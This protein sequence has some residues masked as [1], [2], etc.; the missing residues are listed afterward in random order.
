M[1]RELKFIFKVLIGTIALMVIVPLFVEF[2]NVSRTSSTIQMN[3]TRAMNLSCQY[4]AQETFKDGSALERHNG[5]VADI[6]EN[7]TVVAGTFYP[8]ANER[9]IYDNMF[10]FG[11][12]TNWQRYYNQYGG[13][14]GIYERSLSL[15]EL[16]GA[17]G[18]FIARDMM[19]TPLNMGLT[20]LDSDV[21]RRICTYEI[22]SVFGNIGGAGSSVGRYT[23]PG[24]ITIQNAVFYNGFVMD[25]D[26]IRF[27]PVDP[28]NLPAGRVA[29]SD[30]GLGGEMGGIVY[31][32]VNRGTNA[33]TEVTGMDMQFVGGESQNI[34]F[35]TIELSIDVYYVGVTYLGNLLNFMTYDGTDDTAQV[36][37]GFEGA[38]PI[39]A[40][41]VTPNINTMAQFRAGGIFG[42]ASNLMGTNTAPATGK[43]VYFVVR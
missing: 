14:G 25:L 4:Y 28:A 3:L 26:S 32:V 33:F 23:L 16:R 39:I 30:L 42:F 15:Y 6:S 13:S 17:S 1:S 29:G 20:Y 41:R 24:G 10:D 12:G 27:I 22:A 38:P 11:S 5:N 36:V 2:Y 18:E 9:D 31:S 40:G 37:E 7:G 8:W 35:A 43:I 34:T 19:M 21:L